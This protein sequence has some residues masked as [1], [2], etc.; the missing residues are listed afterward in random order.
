MKLLPSASRI[1][2]LLF[3]PDSSRKLW[4]RRVGLEVMD[5]AA[6]MRHHRC[7]GKTRMC[8]TQ[9]S[10][11]VSDPHS[12]WQLLHSSADVSPHPTP[13]WAAVPGLYPEDPFQAA[14]AD[15]AV[16][17][18]TDSQM[19]LRPTMEQK[20]PEKKVSVSYPRGVVAA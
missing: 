16:D 9:L 6:S 12:S 3:V 7:L 2:W 10:N 18:V 14:L 20:D 1:V 19:K 17:A 13:R 8:V 4:C 11:N 15:I 5:I